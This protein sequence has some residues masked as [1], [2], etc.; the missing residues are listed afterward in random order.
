MQP[1]V[2]QWA[3]KTGFFTSGEEYY[4]GVR[5]FL[6]GFV[7][8]EDFDDDDMLSLL[9]P[10]GEAVWQ[11]R[12]QFAPKARIFGGFLEPCVFI[13]T[14]YKERDILGQRGYAP[15]RRRCRTIWEQLFPQHPRTN[16]TRKQLLE[17]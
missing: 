8:G 15:E 16:M 11:F 7:I 6:K 12:V 1:Q 5:E 14:N 13:A 3:G 9:K 4:A 10:P 2:A 17:W